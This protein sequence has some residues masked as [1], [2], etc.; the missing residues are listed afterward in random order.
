[1]K[2]KGKAKQLFCMVCA[3]VASFML[4]VT[5]AASTYGTTNEQWWGTYECSNSSFPL[6]MIIIRDSYTCEIASYFD[7]RPEFIGYYSG[8][9]DA[10]ELPS[11]SNQF[12]AEFDKA[13]KVNS[14]GIPVTINGEFVYENEY[15][16]GGKISLSPKTISSNVSTLKYVMQ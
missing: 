6:S 5:A 9:T 3:F 2:V 10:F 13:R 16:A 4:T 8:R 7:N 15:E 14:R 1:M 11:H 12:Y